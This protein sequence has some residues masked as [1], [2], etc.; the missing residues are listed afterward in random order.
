MKL[1]AGEKFQGGFVIYFLNEEQKRRF[2]AL[3]DSERDLTWTSRTKL[4][5]T[6]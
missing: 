2:D 5:V 1:T 3:S 6:N 4:Q